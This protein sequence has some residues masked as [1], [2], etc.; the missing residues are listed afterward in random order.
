[1]SIHE[2]SAPRRVA[3]SVGA[4]APDEFYDAYTFD[5][6]SRGL[7]ARAFRRFLRH[8]L[9]TASLLLLAFVLTAGLLA[10]QIAPYTYQQLNIH[11]LG[12]GPSWAHPFGTDQFGRDYFS[13]VLYGIGTEA[14]VALGVALLGTFIGTVVGAVCGYFGGIVDNLLMRFTDLLLTLPPLITLL[15]VVSYLQATT[16]LKVSLVIAALVWMPVARI[17][18]GTSFSLREREYVEAARAMGASDLRIIARHILPNAVGSA[19]VAATVMT[20]GAVILETTIAYLGFGIANVTRTSTAGSLGDVMFVAGQEGLFHWWGVVFPGLAVIVILV[21]IYFIGDGIRDALD[22]V[23]RGYVRAPKPY[24]KPRLLS[25]ALSNLVTALPRPAVPS[26]FRRTMRR[27]G[28]SVVGSAV[29][30]SAHAITSAAGGMR[31][32][33]GAFLARLPHRRAVRRRRGRRLLIEA[34]TIIGVTAAAAGA[35][36]IWKVNPVS[37]SWR[38]AG[39]FVQ[40]VSRAPGAQTEVSVAVAPTDSRILFAASNDSVER[41]VRIYGSSDGGRTWTSAVGPALAPDACAQGEPSVT[42]TP[43]GREY[44][45]FIVSTFC[46]R[47]DLSPYLVVATRRG[48]QGRWSVRR[49]AARTGSEL[50]DAMPA[51]A[52]DRKGRVYVVW[53]R[54]L[55]LTYATTVVSSSTDYGRHWSKPRIVSQRLSQPH[56]VRAAISPRG[57]LYLTGVDARL[58]I[59]VG[60]S[61]DRGRTFKVRRV[62]GLPFESW[63]NP[64]SCASFGQKYPTAFEAIK[65]LGP[66]PTV[67]T[68]ADRVYVTFA[69]SDATGSQHVSTAVVDPSLQPLSQRRVDP[70][71]AQA[72]EQLFPT[73]AVD[74][75]SGKI[76]VCFYDSSGDRSRKQTWFSCTVSDDGRR[77]ARPVRAAQASASPDVLIE[78]ARSFGFQDFTAYGEYTGLAVADGIAHPMWTDT[79]D[80]NGR[81]QEIF[82]ARVSDDD[83]EP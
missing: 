39:T 14:R 11:A 24:R 56:L 49:I 10:E 32:A 33:T 23:E 9:A 35:I 45:A 66:N 7:W 74:S 68:T 31:T 81:K 15:V 50:F 2:A 27:L 46:Q 3:V 54:R 19:T 62:A 80:L 58:G 6:E 70:V 60:Q 25:R 44:V 29:L 40:N 47:E 48:P 73:S 53:S 76:W 21:P 57:V 12:A 69:A 52:T 55:T 38:A 79:R 65:C 83:F 26:T 28:T 78:D 64:E 61:G 30:R 71:K 5:V 77:W 59:W 13:R 42:V 8:R 75:R 4:A 18:R 17:V 1:M 36:Y 51:L 16:V 67:V 82:S 72:A 20:A 22:P 37:S 34:I 41:T 43:D 63:N